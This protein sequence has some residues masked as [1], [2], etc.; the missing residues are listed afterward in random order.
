MPSKQ[1]H[2]PL[3][4]HFEGGA[5]GDWKAT[6]V[7]A[8]V[9]EG[10]PSAP[11]MHM[12][13]A[14]SMVPT[15]WALKG[16]VSNLRYTTRAEVLDLL[17]RSEGLGRPEAVRGVLIPIRKSAAWWAL[18][19]DERREIYEGQSRHTSIGMKYLPHIARRLHHSR[20]LMEP[21]DFLTWFEFAPEHESAF[22][23]LLAELRASKEWTY[24]DRE[25]EFRFDRAA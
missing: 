10:L 20:D 23:D 17:A 21:F 4:V 14:S 12:A 3:L 6:H 25:V 24:V 1:T 11:R 22:D 2:T 13:L 19:Q 16:V 9:G 15:P 5:H 8:L 18:A 7:S